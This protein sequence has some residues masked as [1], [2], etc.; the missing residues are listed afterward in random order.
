MMLLSAM[1]ENAPQ[2]FASPPASALQ[3]V[4]LAARKIDD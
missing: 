3:L 2:A 1:M 4:V